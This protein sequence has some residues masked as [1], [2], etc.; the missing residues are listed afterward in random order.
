MLMLNASDKGLSDS[1]SAVTGQFGLGFKSM[2]LF[3]ER[4]EVVSGLLA[5]EV[6]GALYPQ[7]LENERRDALVQRIKNLASDHRKVTIVHLPATEQGS[8]ET[9]TA[10]FSRLVHI[11]MIFS[12]RIKYC[13][14]EDGNRPNK[15]IEWNEYPIDGVEGMAIGQLAS[16][17]DANSDIQKAAVFRASSGAVLMGLGTHGFRAFSD[18]VPTIWATAPTNV[19]EDLGFALNAKFALD[20]GRAQLADGSTLNAELAARLGRDLGVT[21]S[22]LAQASTSN[23]S[24]LA[25]QLGLAVDADAYRFWE[26]VWLLF[27]K[28]LHTKR[29]SSV[30]LQVVTNV[31]WGQPDAGMMLLVHRH[32]VIPSG[33][34]GDYRTLTQVRRIVFQVSGCLSRHP[35]LFELVS[36]WDG[37][38]ANVQ[39][40]SVVSSEIAATLRGLARVSL[41]SRS[42]GLIDAL[43]WEFNESH[44]ADPS[45]SARL[46]TVLTKAL[47]DRLKSSAAIHGPEHE[48][49]EQLLSTVQFRSVSGDYRLASDF[50]ADAEGMD[51]EERLRAKFAPADRLLASEYDGSALSFFLICR[52]RTQ[53]TSKDLA[54]WMQRALSI[55]TQVACLS[56]LANGQLGR[57][58][59]SH[60]RGHVYSTWLENV[61]ASNAA[62]RLRP[63]EYNL[64]L[65]L[66]GQLPATAPIIDMSEIP[67][68]L[69]FDPRRSLED[70]HTWWEKEGP[71]Q[72]RRYIAAVYP[73]KIELSSPGD[74][75][76]R[77]TD[78]G[79]RKAWLKFLLMGATFTLGLRREQHRSFIEWIER[80]GWLDR[81]SQPKLYEQDPGAIGQ[82][83]RDYFEPSIDRL[84]F[85]HWLRL[86]VS[87]FQ[88]STWLDEYV[89]NFLRLERQS[90][91][92]NLN[93]LLS[94]NA[95]PSLSGSGISAP[96]LRATLGIGTS[97]ILRE[98]V[99][100]GHLTNEAIHPYC[101]VPSQGVRRFVLKI[102]GPNLEVERPSPELSKE[103]HTFLVE[104]LGEER[105]RFGR[106]FDIPFYLLAQNAELQSRVLGI[107]I[108][109]GGDVNV[110]DELM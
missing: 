50:I 7:H 12:R 109:D 45:L 106:T 9:V 11:L 69:T 26:S 60:L 37:F 27:A 84:D 70:I 42:I 29:N 94:P 40:D 58:V 10:R 57:E 75:D 74:W 91:S 16:A 47:I 33:L 28:R 110:E 23:W 79:V 22:S 62:S 99:R 68:F 81:F 95:N 44:R 102:G 108:L 17:A 101:Y 35:E 5:F 67:Y 1:V 88:L 77:R 25:G 92:I 90:G 93:N 52:G 72:L 56:Y 100:R 31:L 48:D 89:E 76:T 104:H 107:P 105:A 2:F 61:S 87:L 103:I 64:V 13:Q 8:I 85:Y 65:V 24:T 98:L 82:I 51:S 71:S 38:A 4:V 59:A 19:T 80:Q 55:E 96:P 41:D 21:L 18:D 14:L 20:V 97:F 39:K 46:G 34:P 49:L 32:D 54:V 30:A 43:K 66:L 36:T 73:E 6:V 63:L 78:K 86:F 53:P 83:L 15:T 3:A